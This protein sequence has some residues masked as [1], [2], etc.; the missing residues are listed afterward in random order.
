M[1]GFNPND[2]Q[3]HSN[4][5][6]ACA[7]CFSDDDIVEFIETFEG[8]PGCLFCEGD[9][10]PTA[11]LDAVADHMR[12]CL[13]SFYS[14]AADHLPYE[15]KE[16]GYLAPHWDSYDLLFDQLELDLPRDRK[17]RLRCMLPDRISEQFWCAYNWVSLEY[18]QE[19]DYAWKKFCRTIQY[20]RRFFFS[21]PKDEGTEEKQWLRD[22]DEFPPLALL[23]EIVKLA[24]EFD[25]VRI[26]SSGTEFF[27]GLPCELC[28]PYRT[29]CELGPPMGQGSSL[30]SN[31]STW[32][33]DDVRS[34]NQG[35]CRP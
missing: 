21:L 28:E 13:M 22:P 24:E 16:G 32:D 4:R 23:T 15:T 34:G 26:L 33:T 27:R 7:R 2:F 3:D 10:A 29:A 25:L 12:E 20:E 35:Y 5:E 6:P 8:P 1:S 14:F 9:D 17:D 18:D 30:Q 19:L 31:E 11:P